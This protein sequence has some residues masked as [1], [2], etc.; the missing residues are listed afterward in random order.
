VT[1]AAPPAPPEHGRAGVAALVAEGRQHHMAGRIEQASARYE[2]ALAQAPDDAE[3]LHLLGM[4][5]VGQARGAEG[6]AMLRRAAERTPRLPAVWYNLGLALTGEGQAE[7]AVACLQHAVALNPGYAEAHLALGQ[8]AKAAGRNEEAA[9]SYRRALKTEPRDAMLL[10]R[11]GT[12]CGDAGLLDEAE[13]CLGRAVAA[14]PANAVMHTNLGVLLQ[15]RE[16]VEESIPMFRRA[17]ELAPGDPAALVRL[18]MSLAEQ[19]RPGEA[20]DCYEAA[21]AAQP[22]D[23]EALF[24][25]GVLQGQLHQ[26]AK[27]KETYRRLLALRPDEVRAR[28][29]LA[30]LHLSQGDFAAGLPEYESRWDTGQLQPS[31]QAAARPRWNGEPIAEGQTLLLHAE[32]GFGDTLQFVSYVPLAAARGGKVILQVPS[33]LKALL[34]HVPGLAGVFG[35]NEPLPQFDVQCPLLSLPLVFATRL[36]TIPPP[37]PLTA[38]P[39]RIAEWAGVR[40]AGAECQIGIAWAGNPKHTNDRSRSVPLTSFRRILDAPRC[41]FHLLHPELRAGEEAEFATLCNVADYRGRI[42][43]FADTA[44]IIGHLDLVIAAD[45]AAAH[46][47]GAMGRPV[48]VLLSFNTDWRWFLGREDSPWYPTAR[49]FRQDRPHSWD[50]VLAHIG[51]ELVRFAA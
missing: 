32:Q 23:P 21:L 31:P 1:A 26:H 51:A 17:L 3:A 44:A 41:R 25:V 50:N 19:N 37:L 28:F 42:R 10:T 14:A 4:L 34:E 24:W 16:R 47:A 35:D 20:M 15:R 2:A 5:R 27:A 48:W 39:E 13:D 45:T 38:P 11:L 43:D 33:Q 30:L 6:I 40:A 7:E 9:A 12:A 8:A 29:N 18:G 49:L 36:D 46:L 22:N